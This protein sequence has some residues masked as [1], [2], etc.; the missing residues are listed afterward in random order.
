MVVM[1]SKRS[2]IATCLQDQ[3]TVSLIRAEKRYIVLSNW[4]SI[5]VEDKNRR[6]AEL[7]LAEKQLQEQIEVERKQAEEMAEARQLRMKQFNKD[8]RLVKRRLPVNNIETLACQ[9]LHSSKWDIDII[10]IFDKTKTCLNHVPGDQ[11]S[12]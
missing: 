9:R 10:L 8:Y 2:G 7:S 5:Q 1:P 11:M 6:H 3:G 4:P 12:F